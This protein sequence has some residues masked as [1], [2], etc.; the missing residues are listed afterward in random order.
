MW[1]RSSMQSWFI[2][3]FHLYLDVLQFAT[4]RL[5]FIENP[6]NIY[7]IEHPTNIYRTSNEHLSKI[8]RT[9]IEHPT[10]I[11]LPSA[12]KC[13]AKRA[14][15]NEWPLPGRHEARLHYERARTPI[16][17]AHTT[18]P[19]QIEAAMTAT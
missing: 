19:L 15:G 17:N 4:F 5:A 2:S 12:G 10:S 11:Y 9:S 16:H 18:F 3:L 6:T 8:Q 14:P 13:E 7:R 1:D